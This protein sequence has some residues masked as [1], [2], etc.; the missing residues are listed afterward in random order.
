[1]T[2]CGR[3]YAPGKPR[4]N[5]PRLDSGL[6]HI[7]PVRFLGALP[8]VLCINRHRAARSL[9]SAR[10]KSVR[11]FRRQAWIGERRYSACFEI[12][13][14]SQLLQVIPSECSP[15]KFRASSPLISLT[16]AEIEAFP[17]SEEP[18]RRRPQQPL[19]GQ[20]PRG[21]LALARPGRP[22]GQSRRNAGAGV[23]VSLQREQGRRIRPR[24]RDC[25]AG[26]DVGHAEG[27]DRRREH[28]D[29]EQRFGEGRQRVAADRCEP[30]DRAARPRARGLDANAR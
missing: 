3:S 13:C 28:R 8:Y 19:D 26:W 10:N 2:L 25:A 21:A 29:R 5:G 22:R 17:D 6:V 24:R 18:E 4:A 15:R 12:R 14:R 16:H 9:W 30:D 27:P 23:G 20:R 7:G 1:M 11:F